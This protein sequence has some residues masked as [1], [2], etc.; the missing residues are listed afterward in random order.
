MDGKLIEKVRGAE[1]RPPFKGNSPEAVRL[2]E[3]GQNRAT[4]LPLNSASDATSYANGRPNWARKAGKSFRGPGAK[5]RQS[6]EIER[7]RRELKKVTE[8]VRA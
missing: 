5:P 8:S 1:A 2:L 3:H 7:L 4:A 6:L